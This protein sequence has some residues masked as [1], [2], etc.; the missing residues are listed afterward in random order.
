MARTPIPAAL[1]AGLAALPEAYI[2]AEYLK[3][4]AKNNSL[5]R[6]AGE[7]VILTTS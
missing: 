2:R 6:A 4:A 5:A 7:P 3:N 1:E